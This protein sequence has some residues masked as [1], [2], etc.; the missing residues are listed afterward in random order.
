MVAIAGDPPSLRAT[1]Y[2]RW[3]GP[4]TEPLLPAPLAALVELAKGPD[5]LIERLSRPEGLRRLMHH[6]WVPPVPLLQREALGVAAG[7]VAAVPVYR[8]AWDPAWPPF[9]ALE[10][11]VFGA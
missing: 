8:M 1:G 10:E 6:L 4:D 3:P 5:T 9:R 7:V 2:L 11:Q